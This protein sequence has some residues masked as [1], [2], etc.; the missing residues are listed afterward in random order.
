MATV[1][2]LGWLAAALTLQTFVCRDMRRLRGVAICA[3]FAFIAYASQTQ[4][5]PVLALHLVLAPLNVWRLAQLR[6]REAGG[7]SAPVDEVTAGAGAPPAPGHPLHPELPH[8][9]RCR[10]ARQQRAL[11]AARQSGRPVRG[12]R[13]AL[14]PSGSSQARS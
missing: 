3:N 12:K 8:W 13:K 6:A 14:I 2:L 11:R 10:H 1:D 9:R 4:L 5:W 7:R